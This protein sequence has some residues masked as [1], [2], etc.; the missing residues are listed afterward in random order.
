MVSLKELFYYL[1]ATTFI[2]FPIALCIFEHVVTCELIDIIEFYF[3]LFA[4]GYGE[5]LV[6]DETIIP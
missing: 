2:N 1:R 6:K 3:T 5:I 4:S